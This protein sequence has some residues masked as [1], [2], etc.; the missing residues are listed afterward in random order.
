[1]G[2]R[3]F[4]VDRAPTFHRAGAG[5][6]PHRECLSP[7]Q[8]QGRENQ[9]AEQ[10]IADAGRSHAQLRLE[11]LAPQSTAASS[12]DLSKPF[13][14]LQMEITAKGSGTMVWA[15]TKLMKVPLR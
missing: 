9:G 5:R 2:R 8:R 7:G 6:Q 4:Q 14:E 15:T 13:S 1:M 11:G 10:A 3:V 12:T